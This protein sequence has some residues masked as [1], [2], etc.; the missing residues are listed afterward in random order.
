MFTLLYHTTVKI[1]YDLDS[2]CPNGQYQLLSIPFI[3]HQYGQPRL[4]QLHYQQHHPRRLARSPK[5][6]GYDDLAVLTLLA[7][8]GFGYLSGGKF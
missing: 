8:G 2:F 5:G 7:Y 6:S 3:S 4:F 1:S